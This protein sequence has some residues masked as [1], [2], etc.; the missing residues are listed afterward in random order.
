M[1]GDHHR[2]KSLNHILKN[3]LDSIGFKITEDEAR[4]IAQCRNALFH[5]GELEATYHTELGGIERPI[6]VS[7]LPNLELLFSDVLLRVLGFDDPQINWN[8]WRD[9]MAF[10]V[11]R[12]KNGY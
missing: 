5:R 8:R 7:E 2:G 9:R 4:Q 11:A 6:K 10:Q 3:F 12:R 1:I